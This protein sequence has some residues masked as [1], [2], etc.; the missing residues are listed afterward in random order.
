MI[1]AGLWIIAAF[2]VGHILYSFLGR[3]MSPPSVY[4]MGYVPGVPV[5]VF[6]EACGGN[7]TRARKLKRENETWSE[8]ICPRCV[9]GRY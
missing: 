5:V 3:H 9:K 4:R 1:A 2:V 8:W 6:C 7:C